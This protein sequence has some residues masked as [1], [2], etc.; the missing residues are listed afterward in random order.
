MSTKDNEIE[1]SGS[2]Q[3][4]SFLS[5]FKIGQRIYTGFIAQIGLMIL[6]SVMSIMALQSQSEQFSNYDKAAADAILI[7]QLGNEVVE[8]QLTQRRYFETSAD[9]D[10][11]AFSKQYDHSRGLADAALKNIT[12]PEKA[13]LIQQISSS[14][15]RYK[16]GFDEVAVLIDR[17]NVLVNEK[18]TP[19]GLRM[20]NELE[21]IRLDTYKNGKHDVSNLAA[22]AEEHVL[23]SMVH[24]QMFQETADK[25]L[26]EEMIKDAQAAEQAIDNLAANKDIFAILKTVKSLVA[27]AKELDQYSAEL[28]KVIFAREEIRATILDKS[29]TEIATSAKAS[30]DLAKKDASAKGQEVYSSLIN[31]EKQLL[32]VA[33]AA[34]LI[35]AAFAFFV[36]RGIT[37]PIG[38]LTTSMDRLAN[39]DLKSIIPGLGRKDEIGVMAAAVEVF[40]QNI[41]RAKRLEEE[42]VE[43]KRQAEEDKRRIMMQMADEFETQIGGIVQAVSSNSTELNASARS[44]TDVSNLTL[45]QATQAAASSQQTTS[46]VQTIAT[47]TEEMTSTI[48]EI[49]QQVAGAAK[50]AMEAT[51]KM[52]ETN[53]QMTVLSETA[54]N[55]GKVVEM[56][57]S[58]AEQTNLLALNATIE[59]ARA[60]EAGKGFA[61]VAGEVKEL[62]GQTTKATEEIAMQIAEVQQ[63]TNQATTSMEDVKHV[64]QHLN[65]VSTAI[66]A[67]MEEQ[68]VAINEVASN[69]HQAAKGTELVNQNIYEVNKASQEAGSASSQVLAS[70]EELAQQS[71]MLRAEV[72]KFVLQVRSA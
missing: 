10:K 55:I 42:Q 52:S 67:A 39:D 5:R 25:A 65:E 70:S 19:L 56:I 44:M 7:A 41:I 61:V 40:K 68:N 3:A 13:S 26:F 17:R 8:L 60:G 33:G 38:S 50:A 46:S 63:A 51:N 48:A 32:V 45:E 64:I 58:I 11:A 36:A 24:A 66:A 6:L 69:I 43:I 34:L 2:A 16:A 1:E 9:S 20:R 18:L 31:A 37:K 4:N 30:D 49:S 29:T 28:G 53:Q 62:A 35:G 21:K 15:E 72:D 22:L 47:A 71:E 14:L 12:E 27:Q 59:S 23:L 57:S 54:D